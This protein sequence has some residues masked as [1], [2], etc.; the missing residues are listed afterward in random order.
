LPFGTSLAVNRKSKGRASL[1]AS[2][3][4]RVRSGAEEDATH[5]GPR[6]QVSAWAARPGT[7]VPAQAPQRCHRDG[8]AEIRGQLA[9]GRHFDGGKHVGGSASEE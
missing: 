6:S 2:K 4:T 9:I 3:L 5:F 8:S 1:V 7:Q